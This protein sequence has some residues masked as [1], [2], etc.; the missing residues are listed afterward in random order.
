MQASYFGM[1][2]LHDSLVIMTNFSYVKINPVLILSFI[3][4]TL[5]YSLLQ[6]SSG[7]SEWSFRREVAF[8][9]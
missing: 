8:L 1:G 4:G 9:P 3:E 2:L 6:M 5:G 7:G